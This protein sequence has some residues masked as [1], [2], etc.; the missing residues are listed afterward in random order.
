MRADTQNTREDFLNYLIQLQQKKQ[1]KNI[2][3]TAHALTFFLD[4]YET[5]SMVI[6]NT[7]NQLARHPDIQDKLRSEIESVVGSSNEEAMSYEQIMGL[8]Y[9]DQVINGLYSYFKYLNL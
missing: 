7:V 2:D 6:A 1:L 4:G 3:M 5:S 9:L 8:E